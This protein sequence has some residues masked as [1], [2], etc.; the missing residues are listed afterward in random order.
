VTYRAMTADALNISAVLA[1]GSNALHNLGV[2]LQTCGLGHTKVAICDDDFIREAPRRERQR[3]K[4][5]VYCLRRVLRD[6]TRWSVA[7]VADSDLAVARFHPA[8]QVLPHHMTVGACLRVVAE[9]GS[10]PRISERIQA[11]TEQPSQG[12]AKQKWRRCS[13]TFTR[14]GNSHA[15]V[16]VCNRCYVSVPLFY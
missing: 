10:A 4:E 2:T 1:R 7:V 6:E 3:V 8:A 12:N 15:L 5:P 16:W 13:P 11:K 14:N 9:V